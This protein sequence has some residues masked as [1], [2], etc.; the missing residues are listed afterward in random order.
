MEFERIYRDMCAGSYSTLEAY[1]QAQVKYLKQ[2]SNHKQ[3]GSSSSAKSKSK[4]VSGAHDASSGGL[5]G[6]TAAPELDANGLSLAHYSVRARSV[7]ALELLVRS[8]VLQVSVL[9]CIL[10]NLS[11]RFTLSI[12]PCALH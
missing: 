7:R 5:S 3:N 4:R 11:R 2:N 12:P 8:G 10:C 6:A 1:I 9:F